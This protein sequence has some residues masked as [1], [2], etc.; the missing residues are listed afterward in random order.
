SGD[1]LSD[2]VNLTSRLESLTKYYGVSLLISESAFQGL[3]D[4]EKYQI[5]FLDRA[6]V[7]GRHKAIDVYEV[8]DGEIDYVREL[9][10]RTQADFALGIEFY[11]LGDFVTAKD[12]FEKVL[13]VNY[14]DK[15]AQL[16]L[17]RIDKLTVTGVPKN[18]DGVWA[19]TQK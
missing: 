16:Y 19:F 8:L 10:L 9:K 5:R 18:W 1:A 12:Y 13:A 2:H 3:K 17:E 4:P 7:K 14:S 15:T 11:R 6:S